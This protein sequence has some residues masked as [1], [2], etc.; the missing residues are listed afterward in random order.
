MNWERNQK[1]IATSTSAEIASALLLATDRTAGAPLMFDPD[2]PVSVEVRSLFHAVPE[3]REKLKEAV[4][5]AIHQWSAAHRIEG[6]RQLAL[7][8]AYLRATDAVRPL[9]SI[10]D[11]GRIREFATW[12]DAPAPVQSLVGTIVKVVAGVAPFPETK[13][14]FESWLYD[15]R[16]QPQCA[17]VITTG[18]CACMPE[19]HHEYLLAF[20]AIAS[21][22]PEAYDVDSVTRE[23]VR[24]LRVPRVIGDL[25][26]RGEAYDDKLYRHVLQAVGGDTDSPAKLNM[27]DMVIVIAGSPVRIPFEPEGEQFRIATEVQ[28][29][30]SLKEQLKWLAQR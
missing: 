24:I 9:A 12:N 13:A 1:F 5:S 29:A 20:W 17:A 10:L 15:P 8:A 16:F 19:S 23:I 22:Y 11:S 6:L 14:V 3:S 28:K 26:V 25:R 4:V 27:R 30:R 2:M 18:L 7:S 21:R